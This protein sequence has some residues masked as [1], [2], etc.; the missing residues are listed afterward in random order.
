MAEKAKPARR[1]IH[2][3][4]RD[5]IAIAGHPARFKVVACGRRWGKTSMGLRMAQLAVSKWQR[6]VWWVA[7]SYSL[8]FHPWLMLKAAFRDQ[9]EIKLEAERYIELPEGGSVTVK[10]ADNPDLLRGV[11]L[12]LV[13]VDEAAFVERRTWEAVLAPAL[14]DR[15][16]RAL[17]ISTPCGRN[18]F[19]EAFQRGQDPLIPHWQSWRYPTSA[20]P[21][22][23]DSEIDQ[24]KA[25]LPART[26]RQEYLAEF[27]ED[28]G[29][30]FRNVKQAATV[31]LDPPPVPIAGHRTY[32][33]VD[34][35]RYVDFTALAVIDADRTPAPWLVALDRFSES[36]WVT[37]RERI[38][39]LAKHWQV[40]TILAEANAMGEPNIE[41]LRDMG[42][43]VEAFMTT[44]KS[45]G[46]LI[47]NLVKAIEE[48]DVLLMPDPVLI[49][50]LGSYTYDVV[51]HTGYTRYFAPPG[52][53]DDTV[54]ALALA[55]QAASR[56]RL[57]LGIAVV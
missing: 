45:K 1:V 49:G 40:E 3:L 6:D 52:L 14:S 15:R 26:F 30:V 25:I 42:L 27:I 4:R 31:P 29:T 12:D 13:I 33:G 41:A 57:M 50:E 20:N 7:P 16:G 28:G 22:I 48:Q 24:M 46:P 9:W 53:H 35:G 10:T 18:W 19:W 32:M 34:F 2:P 56:P 5:Q 38:A 23:P 47:E 43:P 11:G 39:R 21:I 36:N 51:R 44:P 55:W 37:Q 17:L 8:A 54:I